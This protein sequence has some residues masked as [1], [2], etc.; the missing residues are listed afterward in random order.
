M[1]RL[2]HFIQGT[3]ASMDLV[4]EPGER[5]LG[6]NLPR[7][8]RDDYILILFSETCLFQSFDSKNCSIPSPSC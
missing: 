2:C 6:I 4:W 1:Q 7:I 8:W 3:Q 5:C